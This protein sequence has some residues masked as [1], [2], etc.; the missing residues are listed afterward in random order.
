MRNDSQ[1][2]LGI[3]SSSSNV[4]S[5][6]L[7][8][9]A[10]II[11]VVLAIPLT[12]EALLVRVP[13]IYVVSGQVLLSILGIILGI[14]SFLGTRR[15]SEN[16]TKPAIALSGIG[17]NLLATG[18]ALPIV[19]FVLVF[20]RLFEIRCLKLSMANMHTIAAALIKYHDEI[21]GYPPATV[22]NYEGEPLY[23]WRVLLLPFLGESKLYDQFHLD[24]S[25]DSAHNKTL[26]AQMPKVYAAPH[27]AYSPANYTTYYQVFDGRDAVFFS[28]AKPSWFDDSMNRARTPG[29]KVNTQRSGDS[30]VYSFGY[31]TRIA[32]IGDGP[33]NTILFVEANE[34]VPWTQPQD[35][36]YETNKTLPQLGGHYH[37]DFLVA[38]T[39]GA[40][41]V[42]RNKTPET[43]I[44]AAI[45][46]CGGEIQH[47]NW[48]EAK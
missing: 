43:E 26:L 5:L 41:H 6:V 12:M 2:Q 42:V 15:H 9:L 22:F 35:L 31:R 40:V 7:G 24:E 3:N 45:T 38:M 11:T 17:L 13:P 46:P 10:L 20:P 33:A 30:A 16:Q 8:L 25:W 28:G 34:R 4:T 23:S 39:N 47:S 1:K 27:E 18:V 32:A 44:R 37:G 21:G 29:F 36:L 19:M 48:N 14:I